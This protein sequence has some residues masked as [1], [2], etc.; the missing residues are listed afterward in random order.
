FLPLGV[1]GKL[2]GQD[3]AWLF[4]PAIAFAGA[5]LGLSLYTL[6]V[7]LISRRWICALVAFVAAQ[8]A[9]LYG[10]AMW[11]G[12]KEVTAAALVALLAALL[13]TV[14]SAEA[15]EARSPRRVLPLATAIA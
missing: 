13:P 2:V 7:R 4:Q 10:Y 1:G 5:M 6:V 15:L 9:L 14:F 11:S 8:P 3:I 12:I